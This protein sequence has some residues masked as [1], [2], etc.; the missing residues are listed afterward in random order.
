MAS[1]TLSIGYLVPVWHNGVDQVPAIVD[2]VVRR[3]P[4]VGGEEVGFVAS[5]IADKRD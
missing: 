5:W 2:S 1:R 3:E 4:H